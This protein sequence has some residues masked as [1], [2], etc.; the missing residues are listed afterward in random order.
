MEIEKELLSKCRQLVEQS[1]NWG[2]SATWGN[3]DFDQL[4]EKIFDKTKV[5]LSVSTLKRIWGRVRYESFPTTATLNALANFIDFEN[6]REFRQKNPI[7][8]NDNFHET[9][10]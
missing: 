2:D 9:L 8:N 1:L 3:D 4:S 10:F 5:R 7:E 6:W